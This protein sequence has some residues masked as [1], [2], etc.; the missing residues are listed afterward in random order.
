MQDLPDNQQLQQILQSFIRQEKPIGLVGHA[1]AALV[2]LIDADGQSFVKGKKLTGLSNRNG[3]A[4][5]VINTEEAQFLI[6]KMVLIEPLVST[7][8]AH[9]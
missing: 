9:Y 2:S 5:I 1:V 7:L 6:R 3:Q 8:V 4:A